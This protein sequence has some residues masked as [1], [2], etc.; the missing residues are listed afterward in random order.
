MLR[1]EQRFEEYKWRANQMRLMQMLL[2]IYPPIN[3]PLIPDM[4][5]SQEIFTGFYSLQCMLY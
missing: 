3:M 4:Q 5:H 2:D 1:K